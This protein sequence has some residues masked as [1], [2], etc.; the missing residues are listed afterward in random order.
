MTGK[1]SLVTVFWSSITLLY[2]VMVC[3]LVYLWV[4]WELKTR[5]REFNQVRQ[6]YVET[7]KSAIKKQVQ[8][9]IHYI[10]HKKSLAEKRVRS[11]VRS[12][13]LEAWEIASHI[14]KKNEARLPPERIE[15]L[16]HDALF[17][18]V[19]DEG[20]GYYFAEDMAGKERVNRN[21][22][23]LE[24][25]NL[26]ETRDSKGKYIMRDFIRVVRSPEGEG[27]STY[28][29]N[30]PDAPG[31]LVP[32]ISYLKYFAP[33]DWVIGSGKYIA[34]EEE[35]IKREVLAYLDSLKLGEE[36]Y[37]F[38][39]TFEGV[40]LTGPLKGKNTYEIQDANGVKIVQELIKS[41]RSGGGFVT[42]VAP[43][44]KGHRPAPKISYAQ[45]VDDWGWYIGTGVYVDS[46]EKGI[47]RKQDELAHNTRMLIL[48][49]VL[50]LAASVLASVFLA[51]RVSKR[52]GI[53]L[54]LFT[55]F[56]KQSATRHKLL[57]NEQISFS[58]FV[59]LAASANEMLS[60]RNAYEAALARSEKKYRRL[61][62]QSKD[63]FLLIDD[64]KIVDCNQA[65]IDMLG[66][67]GKDQLLSVLPSDISP[68]VQPDGRD[69]AAKAREMMDM[70]TQK[71][72]HRFEWEH[73]RADGSVVPMEVLL[74]AIATEAG[75]QILHTTWR[76]IS[77]R[78]KAEAL[79]IQTE[80]MIT[81]GG[82]AAGMAHELNNPLAGMI[83]SA[84]VI[85]NRM[86]PTLPANVAA[87]KKVGISL[88][89]LGE[90]AR[91]RDILNFLDT[92]VATGDRAAR[93]VSNM[94]NFIRKKP[95][96]KS[97][98]DIGRIMDQS[99]ELAVN[100]FSLAKNYDI[101]QVR[102]TKT[103][104]PDLP[105]VLC[106]EINIQQVFFNMLKNA[107][108]AMADD[109]DSSKKQ[110]RIDI[111][112]SWEKEKVCIAIRDNGPGMDPEVAKRI[113]EPFYTT[114]PVNQG[115]GLGLSVS[116]FIIV[117][118]H[119]GSMD[120]SSQPGQGTE[121]SIYLPLGAEENSQ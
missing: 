58:E 98:G 71:G 64:G 16:I 2:L 83:Q 38:A 63:A 54:A 94:L 69:S 47:A 76:D 25:K 90:Y 42:Y 35:K 119:G 12:R 51:W 10:E 53:N 80:K 70:A 81:V 34:E 31:I 77:G 84:Q 39:A 106:E 27:F 41:A 121:F 108:Q 48:K 118:D 87:A 7:Q 68:P 1:K 33:L 91:Q 40:S 120:I 105:A 66:Y 30:K 65:S 57:E 46:I 45:T 43:R 21:N 6:T 101:R 8:Q 116:Y 26:M 60:E 3:L 18:A 117:E 72:S 67:T 104:A 111:S 113:F 32:K 17:A 52:I 61:F 78:K 20:K 59:P 114:K 22:P 56:F 50:V 109:P 92:I 75:R 9:A 97:F 100:D 49:T 82:M 55:R 24:G 28:H 79:M 73:K 112:I 89:G 74:T 14:W 110:P 4:G 37:I 85:K 88:E 107:A 62:E 115:T 36:G 15:R 5:K 103:Y 96:E 29:W 99:I 13:T 86:N 102:I 23:E 19:W 93:I 44:F 95:G 11:E